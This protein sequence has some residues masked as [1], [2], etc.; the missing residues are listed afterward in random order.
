MYIYFIYIYIYILYIIYILE[1]T[2]RALRGLDSFLYFEF[3][4]K[5]ATW[6]PSGLFLNNEPKILESRNLVWRRSGPLGAPLVHLT[7]LRN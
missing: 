2:G 5:T 6:D 4:L 3:N 1:S 7:A